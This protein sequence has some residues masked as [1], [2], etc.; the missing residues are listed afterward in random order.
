M[1]KRW[2]DGPAARFVAWIGVSI[3]CGAFSGAI[4]AIIVT[5]APTIPVPIVSTT[6]THPLPTTATSTE[7]GPSLVPLA[8]RSS[9]SLV[10]PSVLTRRSSPV[11]GVYRK[12]KGVTPD[13]RTLNDDRLL[14]QAVALTA[15]G[16][17]VT[18]ALTVGTLSVADLTIWHDGKG[19]VVERGV[20]DHLNGTAY[21][22][23]SA[24]EL[25]TPAF[26]DV[27]GLVAGAQLWIERRAGS[28]VPTLVT[29]VADKLQAPDPSSSE[30]AVRRIRLDG[31]AGKADV[32]SPVWDDRGA[33][34]GIVESLEG[35]VPRIVPASTLASSFAL[36]LSGG[37]IRHARLGVRGTDLA[38][39]KIDGNRGDLPT[40]G[41]L[42]KDDRKTG[43]AAVAKDSV[44][45]KAGLKAGDVIVSIERDILDGSSDL[46]E[47]L[48]EYRADTPVTI[49][50]LRDGVAQDVA[51]TLGST[52]TSETIK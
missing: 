22:K 30:T 48:S 37:E 50:Y 18:D 51:L 15:D 9:I 13:E 12:A 19:Y 52:V 47:L 26:G 7:V 33:L 23:V 10:P 38:A 31:I 29:T 28:Y 42:L 3:F 41:V 8:T 25:P 24:T 27:T 39:W 6:S 1:A 20:V 17:F 45:A 40:R 4:A 16:W 43:K 32:G 34:I 46:G 5:P 44:A 49:H 2:V 21:L 36:L 11:A 14:G 35:D